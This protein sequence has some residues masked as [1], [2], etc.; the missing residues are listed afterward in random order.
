[1][2]AWKMKK[3][4]PRWVLD[5]IG[6][7]EYTENLKKPYPIKKETENAHKNNPCSETLRRGKTRA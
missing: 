6:W 1:M 5:A 4:V 2:N 3:S 7:K